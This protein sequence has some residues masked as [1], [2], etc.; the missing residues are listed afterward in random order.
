LYLRIQTRR[1]KDGDSTPIG[2][3]DWT[4]LY[5]HRK[6]A[7]QKLC[8]TISKSCRILS[9]SIPVMMDVRN[10]MVLVVRHDLLQTLPSVFS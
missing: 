10:A 6:V 3:A 4:G 2:A 5:Q 7:S 9:I 1:N 8:V